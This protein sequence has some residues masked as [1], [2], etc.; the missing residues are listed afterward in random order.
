MNFD[1]VVRN[2]QV[3]LDVGDSLPEGT[4][5]SV[6]VSPTAKR[7]VE[8]NGEP[9]LKW[10]LKFAGKARNLP[11]DFAEQHDHYLHGTPK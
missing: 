3:V 4:A 5:V 1:S 9:T 8:T 11:A 7:A 10:M 2:G 6:T